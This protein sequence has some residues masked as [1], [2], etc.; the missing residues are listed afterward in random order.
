MTDMK[1]DRCGGVLVDAGIEIFC[2]NDE[3]WRLDWE[4]ARKAVNVILKEN[5]KNSIELLEANGYIVT[6]KE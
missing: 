6:K 3:C 5:I 2:P 4:S 1:C